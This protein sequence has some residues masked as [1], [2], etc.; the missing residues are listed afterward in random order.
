MARRRSSPTEGRAGSFGPTTRRRSSTRSSRPLA[1]RR[2]AWLVGDALRQTAADTAGWRSL[3]ASRPCTRSY[4]PPLPGSRLREGGALDC[5]RSSRSARRVAH[6]SRSA[7]RGSRSD[8]RALLAHLA[9]P[10]VVEPFDGVTERR[11][12]VAAAIRDLRRVKDGLGLVSAQGD[13]VGGV[14]DQPE[15]DRVGDGPSSY[16]PFGAR[17]VRR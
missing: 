16:S 2:N 4:S 13:R 10:L 7:C 14:L 8:G 15:L 6:R 9:D 17:L 1:I 5:P 12:P 3:L 11:K